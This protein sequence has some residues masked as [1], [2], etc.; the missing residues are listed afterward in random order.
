MRAQRPLSTLHA[1]LA[2]EQL[3][4]GGIVEGGRLTPDGR[5]LSWRY[6]DIDPGPFGPIVPFLI[7][8]AGPHPAGSGNSEISLVDFGLVSPSASALREYLQRLDIAVPVVAGFAPI[9]R[10]TLDTPKGQV[11]LT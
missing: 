1:D 11:H 6:V 10:A 4:S 2:R 9:I 7:E 8:W 5:Q 3:A